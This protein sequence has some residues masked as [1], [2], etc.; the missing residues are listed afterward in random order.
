[1]YVRDHQRPAFHAA[2][3]VD[4]RLVTRMRSFTKTSEISK[5]VFP[6]TLDIDH[7]RWQKGLEALQRANV[8]PGRGQ[9]DGQPVSSRVA[10]HGAGGNGL[11][12]ALTRS[13]RSSMTCPSPPGWSPPTDADLALDRG[14]RGPVSLV[15]LHRGDPDDGAACRPRR[16]QGAALGRALEPAVPPCWALSAFIDTLGNTTIAGVYCRLPLRRCALGLD[17]TGVPDRVITG[18]VRQPLKD[19]VPEWGPVHPRLGATIAYHEMLLAFTLLAMIVASLGAENQF[20]M[21]TLP[22]Y[23]AARHFGKLN[24]YLGVR[25]ITWSSF[26]NTSTTCPAISALRA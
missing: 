3:G 13:R 16:G 5:Q 23:F 26:P 20:G 2:L 19:G 18:P 10:C 6:L 17:R 9:E 15:V 11:C 1:M 25:K 8:R 24:L 4:P 14:P 12:R 22:S 21:W 7:P